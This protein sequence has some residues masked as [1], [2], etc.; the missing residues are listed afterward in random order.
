MF[1]LVAIT[2]TSPKVSVTVNK[3]VPS[4]KER[5]LGVSNLKYVSNQLFFCFDILIFLFSF[6]FVKKMVTGLTVRENDQIYEI[7]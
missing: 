6:F 7:L 2:Y 3:R 1:C 4:K 5:V